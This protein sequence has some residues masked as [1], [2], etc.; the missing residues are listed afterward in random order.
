[1]YDKIVLGVDG[2]DQAGRAAEQARDLARLAG[3]EVRVVHVVEGGAY[4]GRAG[5]FPAEQTPEATELVDGVVASLAAEGVK[6]T[7]MVGRA[8]AGRV[9]AVLADEAR[10]QGA[11]VI[12]LG[13][14]GLGGFSGLVMGS[15]THKVL[16]LAPCPVLVVR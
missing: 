8:L 9:A 1:M 16:H 13:S 6:A 10:A 15:V 11:Q 14:R 5:L 12:V 2:S 4:G 7:G 3:G